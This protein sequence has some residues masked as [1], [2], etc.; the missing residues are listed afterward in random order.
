MKYLYWQRKTIRGMRKVDEWCLIN[1]YVNN[2]IAFMCPLCFFL[3]CLQQQRFQPGLLKFV[4]LKAFKRRK[5]KLLKLLADDTSDH[6]SNGGPCTFNIIAQI[7][8]CLRGFSIKGRH[9]SSLC[10]FYRTALIISAL[11]LSFILIRV[12]LQCT[13]DSILMI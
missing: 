13:M 3:K 6:A 5:K 4:A 11:K 7:F 12:S 2:S 1:D 8:F 10:Q 9:K